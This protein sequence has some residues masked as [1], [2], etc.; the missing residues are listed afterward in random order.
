MPPVPDTGQNV[1]LPSQKNLSTPNVEDNLKDYVLEGFD[2]QNNENSK[3]VSVQTDAESLDKETDRK[4][5]PGD[6]STLMEKIFS[7]VPNDK[8][9]KHD[10][11]SENSQSNLDEEKQQSKVPDTTFKIN[12]HKESQ[13]LKTFSEEKL[14]SHRKR[15]TGRL[16]DKI[17][18]VPSLEKNDKEKR[19]AKFQE[20]KAKVDPSLNRRSFQIQLPKQ[21]QNKDL[22][23]DNKS[24]TVPVKTGET[25]K[26]LFRKA[27]DPH[28]PKDPFR[29]NTNST[30]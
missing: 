9:L 5:E 6:R 20:R 14:N 15:K 25:P 11:R 2:S 24:S 18:A 10:S 29:K 8:N 21:P 1:R 23:C 17:A 28:V 3:K 13:P 22:N 4:N 26:Q 7:K 19:K 30:L 27:M 16:L 12:K